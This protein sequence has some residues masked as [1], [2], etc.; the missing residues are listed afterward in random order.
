[1][2]HFQIEETHVVLKQESACNKHPYLEKHCFP[3]RNVKVFQ[4][5]GLM[6]LMADICTIFPKLLEDFWFSS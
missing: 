5:K 4:L 3:A 1:M 2:P 6:L